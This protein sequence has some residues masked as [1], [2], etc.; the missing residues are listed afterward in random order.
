MTRP[1][2]EIEGK[3]F[4]LVE[5][6]DLR[7]L[8]RASDGREN[9]SRLPDFPPADADG[10]RPALEYIQA[11]IARDIIQERN[12][13]GLTQ[14][15]LAELAGVRRETLARLESGKHPPSVRA[16]EKVDRALKQSARRKLRRVRGQSG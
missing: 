8:Q 11:S 3:R 2:V 7:R 14:Q 10:N 9:H 1:I 6:A 16:V 5:E 12:A 15:E 4:V 13:L